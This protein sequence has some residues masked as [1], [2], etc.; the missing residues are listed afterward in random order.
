[1]HGWFVQPR[2]FIVGPLRTRDLAAR[3]ADL[4]AVLQ[5]SDVPLAGMLALAFDVDRAGRA[6]RVRMLSDTTRV[7]L[8]GE[9]DRVRLVAR[10]RKTVA[11]WKFAKQRGASRVTL[12]LVFERG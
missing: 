12:P 6:Q 9:A 7:A 5:A 4:D 1:M 10:L 3:T 8:G 2:P 11:A